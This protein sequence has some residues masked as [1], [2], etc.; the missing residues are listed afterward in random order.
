MAKYDLAISFAGEDRHLARGLAER[1]DAAGYSIF[2]DEFHQAELWGRDLTVALADVYARE[3]RWCL[4]LVSEAY[5]RKPWTNLERQNA[6][7]RFMNERTGYLLC[8]RLDGSKLPGL[9]D[10]V[11]YLDYPGRNEE[12]VYGLLLERL[13]QPAHDDFVS[14]VSG[15]DRELASHIIQACYRRAVFTRMDSEIDMHAMYDSVGEAIGEVQA[16]IP[17]IRDTKLQFVAS[18][19]LRALDAIERVRTQSHERISNFVERRLAREIDDQKRQVIR[20]LLEV[21]RAAALP[22]QM[23]MALR[24]DHFFGP[25][26]AREPPRDDV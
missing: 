3:A 13:G 24:T 17:R 18:K 11:G 4:V 14:T 20:L 7:H 12:D 10:V 25:E 22:I 21:R 9:P 1:L 26:A 2:F 16:A 6:L 5:I 19:I 15:S 8:L 23:P